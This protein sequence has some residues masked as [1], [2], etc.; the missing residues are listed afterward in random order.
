MAR[1]VSIPRASLFQFMRFNLALLTSRS[2]EIVL[3]LLSVKAKRPIA[4]FP[5]KQGALNPL[6]L[7][8]EKES[9]ANHNPFFTVERNP[10]RQIEKWPDSDRRWHKSAYP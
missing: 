7:T 9:V 3:A 6:K 1:A 10:L 8:C 5:G 2:A 4:P